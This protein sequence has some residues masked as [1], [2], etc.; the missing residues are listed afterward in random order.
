MRRANAIACRGCTA[1]LMHQNLLFL[2]PSPLS[3][4]DFPDYFNNTARWSRIH[5]SIS[6]GMMFAWI[7][8]GFV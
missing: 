1:G 4:Y 8:S 5:S 7:Y 3:I 2:S 6:S